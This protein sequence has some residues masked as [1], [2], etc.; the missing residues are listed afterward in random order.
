MFL[1]IEWF[2]LSVTAVFK[3]S[4]PS[5]LAVKNPG[6]K[7]HN[8]PPLSLGI[9]CS[10]MFFKIVFLKDFPVFTGKL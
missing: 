7:E 8:A 10:Q 6:C 5:N 9:S 2:G 3:R 1:F 4:L